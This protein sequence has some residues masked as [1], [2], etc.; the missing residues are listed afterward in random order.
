MTSGGK[1]VSDVTHSA[2]ILSAT[3]GNG[4]RGGMDANAGWMWL[5]ADRKSMN[6]MTINKGV[7]KYRW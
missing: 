4:S 7:A 6:W 2:C 5:T 1:G 3:C